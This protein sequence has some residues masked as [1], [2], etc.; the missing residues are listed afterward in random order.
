[1]LCNDRIIRIV[2]ASIRSWIPATVALRKR[3]ALSADQGA[4]MPN[5]ADVR[6]CCDCV[7]CSKPDG[8]DKSETSS[9]RMEVPV[10]HMNGTQAKQASPAP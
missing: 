8:P 3:K 1:M 2:G 9:V 6:K 7:K 4:M 5:N 10:N